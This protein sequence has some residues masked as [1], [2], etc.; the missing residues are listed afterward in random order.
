MRGLVARPVASPEMIVSDAG[1]PIW[2]EV[3]SFAAATRRGEDTCQEN[4]KR[5]KVAATRRLIA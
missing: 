2:T 5:G 4:D 1:G 3:E